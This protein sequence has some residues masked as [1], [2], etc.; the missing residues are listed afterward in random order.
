MGRIVAGVVPVSANSR[1]VVTILG[2]VQQIWNIARPGQSPLYYAS[3]RRHD[4]G[5]QQAHLSLATPL[6]MMVVNETRNQGSDIWASARTLP[7][8]IVTLIRITPHLEIRDL[9]LDW[10]EARRSLERATANATRWR[11]VGS[12][13][14]V[15]AEYARPIY[16][17]S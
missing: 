15:R 2:S 12:G 10:S 11:A 5:Y 13:A 17:R 16:C 3:L 14:L 1:H 6:R 4:G 7:G 9:V 8:E